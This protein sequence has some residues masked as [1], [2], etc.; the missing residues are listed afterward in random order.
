MASSVPATTATA[1]SPPFTLDTGT[2]LSLAIA[3][4]LMP[5][6]QLLAAKV[7]RPATPRKYYLLFLWHAY[8]FLTHFIIEGSYLYHCFFSYA[9][10]PASTS[11]KHAAGSAE[12]QAYLFNRPDRRYGA[13]YSQ[14]PMARLWQEYAKADRRWGGADLTVISLEVLTVGLAGPVAVYICYLIAKV[15]NSDDQVVRARYQSR[16]WFAAVMLATGELYGGFMTFAPE[17]LSGNTALAGEDPVYLWLYL[18]FFNTLW[19]FIPFW[20]LHVAYK[21]I[22]NTFSLAYAQTSTKKF[23]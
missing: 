17:W 10:L 18:V 22:S 5:S 21:E 8:D 16:L 11:Q 1:T 12:A 2:A 19:V 4:S 3:F 9:E 15:V 20:V 6:A 14:A 23:K 13:L 7:L